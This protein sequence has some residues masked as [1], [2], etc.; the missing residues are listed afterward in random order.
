M[1]Q[2]VVE[3]WGY[4]DLVGQIPSLVIVEIYGYGDLVGQISSLISCSSLG[5]W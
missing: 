3:F 4:S 2:L 1:F 5:V